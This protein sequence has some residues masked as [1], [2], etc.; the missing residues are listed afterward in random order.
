MLGSS[1]KLEL[2]EELDHEL[3]MDMDDNGDGIIEPLELG[4][5]SWENGR[6]TSLIC[7]NYG[8]SG[9]IPPEI[10]NLTNLTDL[11]VYNNQLT[12]EIPPEIGNLTNLT[13]LTLGY[14]QLTGE[15]PE[16]ICNQGDTSPSLSN[17]KLCPPYPECIED[18]VGYQDTSNCE[19]VSIIDETLPIA[20]NLH[21]AYPN[22]FNPTTT[23]SFAIP[24]DSEVSLSI[25]NL[26]GREVSTLIDA[27]MDAGYHSVVW[28]ADNHT[29]VYILL[30]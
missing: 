21:N 23:L 20:Y 12:G 14:N 24:V 17:N 6:L 30:R 19:Q 18:Y 11:K 10:G 16:E 13:G 3:N 26:Q 2:E 1:K 9:E 29:S 15:I 25:Y 27:N 28:N 5:Q 7:Y 8:L 22:P 4:N